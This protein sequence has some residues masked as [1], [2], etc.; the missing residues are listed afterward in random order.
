M[1]RRQPH[2]ERNLNSNE[3]PACVPDNAG[4]EQRAAEL[5]T[6]IAYYRSR[7]P[8]RIQLAETPYVRRHYREVVSA[9]ALMP[10][11]HVCEWGAGL[12]RFSRLLLADG[13]RVTA[14]E[15]SP[16][17]AAECVA[18]LGD[19][20]GLDVQCGDVAQVLDRTE[21]EFDAMLGFFMLHHLPELDAYFR[22]AY[23]RLKPG[24][25]LVC[26]EPNPWHPLYPL[27]I[28]L[29]PG[30]RWAAERGIYR[31]TPA[32]LRRA[33]RAAGFSAL[34]IERYGSLPRAP[35]NWLARFGHERRLE[36]LLPNAIKPFQLI[37]LGK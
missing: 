13:L 18:T 4:A 26:V 33:A 16:D 21:I 37:V 20:P 24:G 6:Q 28:S 29:T 27:Q 22:C 30:M 31:L 32:N 8:P 25:R 1:A 23:A 12:G 5:D 15:L 11:A 9:A 17:L 34:K 19:Q 3:A 7:R 10:G 36:P 2:S 35:Y 14:I